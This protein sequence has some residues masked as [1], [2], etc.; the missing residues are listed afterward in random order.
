VI[1]YRGCYRDEGNRDFPYYT[2][3]EDNSV[4]KCIS[5]CQEQ[6]TVTFHTLK[7]GFYRLSLLIYR[8]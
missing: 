4:K 1:G 7:H 2:V 3:F 5:H 6:G 8:A